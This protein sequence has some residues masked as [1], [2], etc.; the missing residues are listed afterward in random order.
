LLT[1]AEIASWRFD[2]GL[3]TLSGCASASPSAARSGSGLLGLTRA[4]LAA[5]ARHV[6][7]TR[8]N[9]PDESGALFASLYRNLGAAPD[10]GPAQSLR[11]AQMEMLRSG[12]WQSQPRYWGAYFVIGKD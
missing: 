11:F 6:I 9:I 10:A 1:P 8:W 5:G 12:G 4:W 3:I 2:L 7:A